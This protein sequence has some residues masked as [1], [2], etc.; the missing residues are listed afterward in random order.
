MFKLRS[1]QREASNAAVSSFTT[2][3]SKGGV[4]ILPTG[5]GKSLVI[6]D[7]ASRLDT[8]LLV[9]QPSKEILEQNFSKLLSYDVTDCSIYSASV[10]VKEIKRI[11]FATIGSVMG[12]ISYFDHFK[13]VLIDE[14]HLVNP[15]CGQYKDFIKR[16]NRKVIGLTATPYRL[17]SSMDPFSCEPK[18]M[19][20]FITRTRPKVFSDVLYYC[21]IGEL[22]T[23]GYLANLKYFDMTKI[24]INN[25]S[26]NS[27]GA[28]YNEWSLK[29]E[30]ERVE[31]S[32]QLQDIVK[33]LKK[34]KN[35]IKRNGIL[36]FTSLI[37][38]A[39]KLSKN[40]EGCEIIT[41]STPKKERQDI[42]TRFKSGDIDVVAN[43]G[44]LTTGFD[45][46]ALDTVV[47]ARP[48]MSL[49]LYYQMVGRAIRPYQGK[50]GWII[51]L[52]GN[53]KRFGEV[54][55]LRIEEPSQGEWMV[56]SEGRQLTNIYF[57]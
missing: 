11:T 4:L 26:K 13:Y 55:K 47:I 20:K 51:D 31:L 23:Q 10:G 32:R 12:N 46:P 9:F 39:T 48:T 50:D 2:K 44:V 40:I 52:C 57:E 56:T 36:V 34:P 37:S 33:R 54:N 15:K 45:Y 5:A 8:P 25:L 17:H 7:I 24:D 30:F 3:S 27:T 19:L 43:V 29:I 41:G 38:E 42:L 53:I 1:Y 49:A 14:C 16:V 18:S 21:Q 35:G 28:D 6:A 22:L